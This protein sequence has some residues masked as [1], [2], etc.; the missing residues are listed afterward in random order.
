MGGGRE[1]EEFGTPVQPPAGLGGAIATFRSQRPSRPP[2]TRRYR[3]VTGR[4]ML[5]LAFLLGF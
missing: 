1:P 4:A 3:S 5:A 2:T